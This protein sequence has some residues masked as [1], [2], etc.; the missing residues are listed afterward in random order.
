MG[1]FLHRYKKKTYLER[2]DL[3]GSEVSMLLQQVQTFS[4]IEQKSL[5]VIKEI[6]YKYLIT[7]VLMIV[8]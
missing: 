3:T 5:H 1:I 2:A 7:I 6:E 8:F 4:D